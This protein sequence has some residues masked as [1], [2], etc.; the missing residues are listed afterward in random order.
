MSVDKD[1]LESLISQTW[2]DLLLNA[3]ESEV[4]SQN[5]MGWHGTTGIIILTPMGLH[6]TQRVNVA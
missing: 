4:D 3:A 6:G 2:P 1:I 5:P